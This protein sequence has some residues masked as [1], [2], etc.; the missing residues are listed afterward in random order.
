MYNIKKLHLQDWITSKQMTLHPSAASC[1][2]ISLTGCGIPV[3]LWVFQHFSYFPP[4]DRETYTT[5]LNSHK[6][7]AFPLFKKKK[8]LSD[9]FSVCPLCRRRLEVTGPLAAII[10][11]LCFYYWWEALKVF[12]APSLLYGGDEQTD[13]FKSGK[14]AC[15]GAT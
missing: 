7:F 10:N 14:G 1:F 9:S 2:T 5:W 15:K 13:T 8:S 12:I 4:V 11:P 3:H 6:L